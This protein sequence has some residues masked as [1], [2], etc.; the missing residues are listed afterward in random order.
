M[1]ELLMLY[2]LIIAPVIASTIS[3][4]KN[5]KI[6]GYITITASIITL[7]FSLSIFL[8]AENISTKWFYVDSTTASMFLIIAATYTLASMHSIICIQKVENFYLPPNHYWTFLNIFA[9]TMFLAVS[10][11]DLGYAWLWLEASTIASAVLILMEK[12]KT[13]IES[14]W[15]YIII[16]STGLGIA[17]L[18]VIIFGFVSGN[19]LWNAHIAG[20]SAVLIGVLALLGF[21]TKAGLFPVHTWLP[22][23][24]GTAPAPVSAMLSGALLPSAL[25]VYYRVY[26]AVASDKLF[27][28]T[29]SMGILTVIIA[30][31]LLISQRKLKR[32]LAYSTMDV[33]GLATV[34]IALTYYNP[35][36]IY[37]VLLLFG[38]HALAKSALFLTA[39]TLKRVGLDEISEIRDLVKISPA[40]AFT[41]VVSSLAV[42]G[43]P[44]F[45]MFIGEF[46]IIS[47]LTDYPLAFAAF[48]TGLVLSFLALNYWMV[49]MV[50]PSE[51]RDTPK[52]KFKDYAVPFF[53][54]LSM[55]ILSIVAYA[56]FLWG[57][58]V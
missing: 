38:L 55:V 44:P 8:R 24:H 45:A 25:I 19:F 43:A 9:L 56:Y 15:R 22:D 46:G 2:G 29:L 12:G 42:T 13:H 6:G 5:W 41:V 33:M 10:T 53:A 35:A 3:L 20:T 37:F 50:F 11:P 40:M 4:H 36:L 17:L 51:N 57:W 52:I 58:F 47:Q 31:I 16:A 26:L 49:Q 14:A 1:N 54:S 27:I 30:G 34:G 48:L 23:A 21:G 32:L 7:L 39:G 18:S 28:I